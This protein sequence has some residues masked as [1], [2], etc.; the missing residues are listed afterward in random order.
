LCVLHWQL[1]F[2]LVPPGSTKLRQE[3]L[4]GA[5]FGG[6]ASFAYRSVQ[7]TVMENI[8]CPC[9]GDGILGQLGTLVMGSPPCGDSYKDSKQFGLRIPQYTNGNRL[10]ERRCKGHL[11][12]SRRPQ[13]SDD[14]V[15]L[16]YLYCTYPISYIA[17]FPTTAEGRNELTTLI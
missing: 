13:E 11:V 16:R 15:K 6:I 3:V 8:I 14:W 7:G 4:A 5:P 9:G 2:I 17:Y 10:Y 1:L 12:R